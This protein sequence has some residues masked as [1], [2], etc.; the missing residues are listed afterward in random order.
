MG[1]KKF[2]PIVSHVFQIIQTDSDSLRKVSPGVL[3]PAADEHG[4]CLQSVSVERNNGNFLVD[5]VCKHL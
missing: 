1:G 3:L 2:V 4:A 5:C